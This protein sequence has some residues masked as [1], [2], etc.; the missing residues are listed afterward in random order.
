[1]SK[2]LDLINELKQASWN[3]GFNKAIYDHGDTAT[4]RTVKQRQEYLNHKAIAEKVLASIRHELL[5]PQS[6]VKGE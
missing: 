4:F 3:E 1:M 5:T 2:I 6:A